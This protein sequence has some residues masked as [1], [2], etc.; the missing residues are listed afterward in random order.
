VISHPT[1]QIALRGNWWGLAGERLHRLF[2]RLSDSEIVS[3]IPGS[4][5]QPQHYGVPYSLTEEFVA[6]YRMHPLIPD[7]YDFRSVAD[8]H[9]IQRMPFRDLTGQAALEVMTK[10]R[11]TDLLYSLGTMHPGLVTLHNFPRDLQQF[12]RPDG[13]LMDL[14]AVDILRSR[15]LGVPR[16]NVFRRLLHLDPAENFDTLTDNPVWA[17]EI[18]RVYRGDIEAVDL[19]VGMFAEPRPKGFAFSDTAFRIFALMASRRLNSDRFFT[20]D[21][22]PQ[23]YTQVGLDW[24]DDNTM[25][26]VLLRH[27]PGLGPAMRSITN[28]FMPWEK[29]GQP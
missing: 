18:R 8:D 10:L 26:T 6:V 3:G 4:Q 29:A 23:V 13:Q 9:S 12:V 22:T 17:E 5:T 21:Y 24:I 11:Q 16:Y 2:G 28:A 20:R 19:S 27:H 7:D 25:A 1:T 14:G 15:E